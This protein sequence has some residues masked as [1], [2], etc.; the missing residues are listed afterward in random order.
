MIQFVYAGGPEPASWTGIGPMNE[1]WREWLRDWAGFRAQAME[2]VVVDD[3]RILAIV[4]NTG[5][6]KVSGAELQQESVG[7]L[8]EIRGGRVVRLVVYLDFG[9]ARTDLGLEE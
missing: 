4:R 3:S 9:L 2:Y 8:F 7:N 5:R 6:G 1:R